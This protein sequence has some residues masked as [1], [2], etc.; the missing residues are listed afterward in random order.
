MRIDFTDSS[1]VNRK[2]PYS[3]GF[4][5][6]TGPIVDFL[7]I[8]MIRD[9]LKYTLKTSKL[10]EDVASR[11]IT[12]CNHEMIL[13]RVRG[14][15]PLSLAWKAAALPLSYTRA[16]VDL[17]RRAGGLNPPR[18]LASPCSESPCSTAVCGR[19]RALTGA[20]SLPILMFPSTMKGGDPVSY[21]KRCHLAGIAR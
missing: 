18:R 3:G 15:E 10:A 21:T 8:R 11:R 7:K 13:E 20:D 4:Y 17:T 6:S 1:C 2:P 12:P 16:G 9:T 19:F 14:I 5:L